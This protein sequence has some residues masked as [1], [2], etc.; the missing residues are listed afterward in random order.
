MVVNEILT[1]ANYNS[2]LLYELN[3]ARQLFT[4]P[5]IVFLFIIMIVGAVGNVIVI[6]V[7]TFLTER[8]VAT[9]YILIVALVDMVCCCFCLPFQIY[10][11]WNP[12]INSLPTLCRINRFV[13]NFT[14]LLNGFILICVASERYS[15]VCYPLEP[16]TRN[17]AKSLSIIVVVM[18]LSMSWPQLIITGKQ[19]L[20]VGK[21]KIIGEDCSYNDY[22]Q[23]SIYVFLL[24]G[25]L[26]IA[27]VISFGLFIFFYLNILIA[28]IKRKRLMS[29]KKENLT[30]IKVP[31]PNNTT[32]GINGR[33][34][35]RSSKTT[36][37]LASVT[38]AAILTY[39]PFLTIQTIRNSGKFFQTT[40]TPT[41]EYYHYGDSAAVDLFCT[42]CVKS[43]FLNS[44]INPI[45]YSVM[46]PRFRDNVTCAFKQMFKKFTG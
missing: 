3:H 15:K 43:Y 18:A 11:L 22:F 13:E 35:M 1:D 4:V 8:T 33:I 14:N 32:G 44:A 34:R 37:C 12:Y 39:V 9:F 21:D 10:D 23:N 31:S 36:A 5:V 38:L 20:V 6:I 24:M 42:F 26:Y 40:V 16:Y 28:I 19:T 45:I 27:W 46:N 25:L 2:T 7:Y 29:L 30:T 41:G 17:K